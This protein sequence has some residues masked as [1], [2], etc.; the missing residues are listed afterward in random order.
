MAEET[1]PTPLDLVLQ[2]LSLWEDKFDNLN[3]M[4][5]RLERIE[6]DIK[7]NRAN[8][9]AGTSGGTNAEMPDV[10]PVTDL[11]SIRIKD[12]IETVPVFDGHKPPVFQFLRACERAKSM[13]PAHMEPHLVK[14]LMNKLRGHAFLA[15]EDVVVT[16]LDSFSTKLKDMFGPGKTINEYRGE[17]GT[18]Y[19]K[20]GEDV[21]DYIDRVRNLRLA[22]MDGERQARGTVPLALQ[23]GLDTDSQEAF[24]NG[25]PAEVFTRVKLE[26]CR[27]L[28][29]SYRAAIK[30]TREVKRVAERQ[31]SYQPPP[32]R[33]NRERNNYPPRNQAEPQQ[34]DQ[35]K[36]QRY[37]NYGNNKTFPPRPPATFPPKN[38]GITCNYCKKPGHVLKDC[39]R[40]KAKV[41]SGEIVPYSQQNQGNGRGHPGRPD[42][43]RSGKPQER[44]RVAKIEASTSKQNQEQLSARSAPKQERKAWETPKDS[45]QKKREEEEDQEDEIESLEELFQ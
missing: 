29:E 39:Y 30:A 21:L 16:N 26:G 37:N 35:R 4:N 40:F 36:P 5:R 43:A 12:A 6:Q 44:P 3:S 45:K 31:R 2:Q 20:S 33:F 11:P 7:A 18:I 25:L 28:D 42:A 8:D 19:Q 34:R 27:D 23:L 13:L 38:P 32:Q 14:L 9:T 10:K 15:V 22:I 41:D 1:T 17:L 24:V